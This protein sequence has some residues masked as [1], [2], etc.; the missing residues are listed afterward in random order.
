MIH[1]AHCVLMVDLL[2]DCCFAITVEE[3]SRQ[4]VLCQI[5]VHCGLLYKCQ[6]ILALLHGIE[7]HFC[8]FG[9]LV[10]DLEL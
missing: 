9:G 10:L 1:I 7:D 8:S 6:V 5:A 4:R 3:N 2:V